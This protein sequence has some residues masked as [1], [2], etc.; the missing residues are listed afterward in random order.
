MS[1][2]I[3]IVDDDESTRQVLGRLLAGEG[4]LTETCESA[5]KA[6][7]LLLSGEY[8]VLL[9][10]LLMDDM[11][12]LELVRASREVSPALR[13][14]I[15]TGHPRTEGAGADVEWIAKPIDVDQLLALLAAPLLALSKG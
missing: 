1:Q 4:Y 7:Q 9:T 11:T 14:I 12:G 2:R 5:V 3:L 8:D 15:M 10:D 13:R 6:L